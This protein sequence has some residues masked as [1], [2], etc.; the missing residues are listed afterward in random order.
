M[1]KVVFWL[2]AVTLPAI[3]ISGL[4]AASNKTTARPAPREVRAWN[5]KGPLVPLGVLPPRFPADNPWSA[6]KAELGRL[7][8]FDTRL[9]KDGTVSCATCHDPEKGFTDNKPVSDGI[10]GFKGGMSSPTVIGRAYGQ[11]QFWD[12]R[13]RSLEEQAGGPMQNPIEMGNTHETVVATLQ[14]IAGYRA[15]F[16]KVFGK[17]SFGIDEVT[18][19]IATYERT[20]LS[21]NSPYDRFK[22]GNRKALTAAQQRGF[23]VYFNKAKCDQCHEGINL[24]ANAFHN[25]GVGANRSN[26]D[27]GRFAVTKRE[28]DWGQF[29]T[30]TLRDIARTAP[31]MHDGSLKTLAEVVDFYDKGGEKNRNLD[32]R[33]KPLNLSAQEKKDLVAFLESLNGEGWMALHK[34]PA[35]F[36]Q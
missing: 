18:K 15:M 11:L 16:A 31:Y 4:G 17:E 28:E 6:E 1:R 12:G 22:A 36:P 8:Y 3:F 27:V 29:K 26:P 23:D 30:P 32:E 19:A 34:A 35:S 21:G 20:V 9:S 25:L 2:A 24:T 14:G 7:L 5:A 10:A 13:A 33:M